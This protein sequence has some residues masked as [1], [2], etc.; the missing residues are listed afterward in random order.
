MRHTGNDANTE[1][2][3]IKTL[4][5]IILF[6]PADFKTAQ[7]QHPRVKN[8]YK[9]KLNSVQSILKKNHIPPTAFEIFIRIFK[10][11][12][13]LELWAREKGG[14][15]MKEIFCNTQ[16]MSHLICRRCTLN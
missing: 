9:C 16:Y 2:I 5:L 15:F 3:A 14:K 10:E 1:N 12:K 7:M 11:E 6:M 8:A 13:L 4:I